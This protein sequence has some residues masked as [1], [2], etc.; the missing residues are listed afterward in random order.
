[1]NAFLPQGLREGAARDHVARLVDGAEQR[2]I[3]FHRAVLVDARLRREHRG[4]GGVLGECE[5]DSSFT[6][7]A[8]R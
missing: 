4:D 8:S 5:H 7:S 6:R 3:A 2:G 1:M